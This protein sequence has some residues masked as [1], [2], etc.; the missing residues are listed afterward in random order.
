MAILFP[1]LC[2]IKILYIALGSASELETLLIIAFSLKH[3]DEIVY[4]HT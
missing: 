2:D 3:I 4:T 1:V